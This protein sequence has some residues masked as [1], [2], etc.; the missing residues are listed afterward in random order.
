VV[1]S[2]EADHLDIYGDLKGVED[3]F[4]EFL[5]QVRDDGLIAVCQ[6]DDG[7]RRIG[8]L[9]A[10]SRNVLTYG[11]SSGARLRAVDVR[12]EGRT[13]TFTVFDGVDELGDITLGAPGMHNV[14]NA[15]G[16][17]A[18]AR[19]AGAPFAAAQAAL[20]LFTGVSRR[21][22][23]LGSPRGITVVDDYAHHPTE[24][25][26]TIAAARGAYPQQRIVAAFQ[27]H[28]YSRTRDLA[29]EFGRSLAAADLVWITDVYP[30]REAPI[31]GVN[32][33]LIVDAA[34]AAGAGDVR[35]AVSLAE[36]GRGLIDTLE[37]GDVL[38]AMGAGDIDE[39]AHGMLA[40]LEMGADV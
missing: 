33:Q 16:A 18:L 4:A 10:Q 15:L 25:D 9:A 40:T 6:D 30:A 28:L 22:Q 37:N 31:E 5:G 38:L 2:V 26:A 1:T 32:G 7:A 24:I 17:I 36:L 21:F 29:A 34:L 39:V 23:V 27:P 12:Q 3:A 19:Y 14:R 35:Y 13:M 20:P 8:V 11:T